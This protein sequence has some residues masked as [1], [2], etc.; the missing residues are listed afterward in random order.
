[1]DIPPTE[2]AS[3]LKRGRFVN[4]Y[5]RSPTTARVTLEDNGATPLQMLRYY[6]VIDEADFLLYIGKDL[7]VEILLLIF[8]RLEYWEAN[9]YI[10]DVTSSH[11]SLWR[12]VIDSIDESDN[13]LKKN[14]VALQI[15]LMRLRQEFQQSCDDLLQRFNET[16]QRRIRREPTWPPE[17]D[18]PD[19]HAINSK[20]HHEQHLDGRLWPASPKESCSSSSSSASP[21]SGIEPKNLIA[22]PT[23]DFNAFKLQSCQHKADHETVSLTI[24]SIP[25]ICKQ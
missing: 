8:D 24:L 9:R 2:A 4:T 21:S 20:C 17:F 11:Y 3:P 7:P 1:M 5:Q 6:F 18:Q 16:E 23:P 12:R 15:N 13:A 10:N 25:D 22:P 19:S 14:M